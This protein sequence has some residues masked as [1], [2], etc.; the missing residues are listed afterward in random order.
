MPVSYEVDLPD[1]V[2]GS[3]IKVHGSG[4]SSQFKNKYSAEMWSGSAKGA[5]LRL[6]D[7]CITQLEVPE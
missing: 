2:V 7:C 6:I 4:Y 1:V 5:Y 3:G